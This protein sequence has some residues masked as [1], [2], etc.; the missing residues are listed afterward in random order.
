MKFLALYYQES[1]DKNAPL[2]F[3]L[4]G[5]GVSSWMWDRQV[6]YFSGNHCVTV[7][8]PE[9][10]KSNHNEVFSIDDSARKI[11]ALIEQI[12]NGKSITVVGFSLGAQVFIKM[13]SMQTDLIDYAI[14]NSALVKPMRMGQ[15]FIGPLIGLSFPL[16][17]NKTFAKLQAKTL[18]IGKEHFEIYYNESSQ[19]KQHTLVRVLNENMSFEIPDE[20][21]KANAKILVTVGEK[22]KS[23]M[24]KSA[25]EIVNMNSNCTGVMISAIGHGVS[26]AAPD[27]FNRLIEKWLSNERLPRKV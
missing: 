17:K 4:H 2:I 12:K 16:M 7:D 15:M 20:F 3:F 21:S 14:I 9:H 5:G 18:Y 25:M 26:L 13:V 1:G 10:G 6:Q 11:I 27:L 24:K 8:L 23:V 19:I 22:E